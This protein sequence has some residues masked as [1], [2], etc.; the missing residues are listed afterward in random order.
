MSWLC[1][2]YIVPKVPMDQFQ[3][4]SV[5]NLTKDRGMTEDYQTFRTSWFFDL[6]AMLKTGPLEMNIF[7][8]G[9]PRELWCSDVSS[10]LSFKN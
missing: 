2:Q 1:V 6:I 9:R 5:N 8:Y 7:V 10:F 3:S 4:N